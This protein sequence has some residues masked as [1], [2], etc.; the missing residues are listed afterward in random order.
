M[1]VLSNCLASPKGQVCELVSSEGV[2]TYEREGTKFMQRLIAKQ[3]ARVKDSGPARESGPP[4]ISELV[5]IAKWWSLSDYAKVLALLDLPV[6][7]GLKYTQVGT[8]KWADPSWV[9][10]YLRPQISNASDDKSR[11]ERILLSL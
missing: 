11:F 1:R 5:L 3:K 7:A 10:Q 6:V 4:W 8:E 2:Q 9:C